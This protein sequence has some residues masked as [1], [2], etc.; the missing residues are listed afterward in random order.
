MQRF[1]TI[2][3]IS[4]LIK[5][6]VSQCRILNQ[7][8]KNY[9]PKFIRQ[10]GNR[11]ICQIHNIPKVSLKGK[12][13]TLP[14]MQQK[15]LLVTGHNKAC[16]IR[17]VTTLLCRR[18]STGAAVMEPRKS[19]RFNNTPYQVLAPPQDKKSQYY[20]NLVKQDVWNPNPL[21]WCITL[22]ENSS[23]YNPLSCPNPSQI[24]TRK[25]LLFSLKHAQ[26][27]YQ[28]RK[29][30]KKSRPVQDR[31]L[32]GLLSNKTKPPEKLSWTRNQYP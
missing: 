12:V 6:V 7:K 4:S 15:Q 9:I 14:R 26:I 21:S 25:P 30:N 11:K 28:W 32:T 18:P 17:E 10:D 31:Y 3:Q 5:C 29:L 20:Q 23:Q 1:D 13:Y 22:N 27:C 24:Q 8:I 2:K 16:Y 19:C